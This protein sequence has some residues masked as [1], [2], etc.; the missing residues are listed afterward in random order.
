MTEIS[1]TIE[2]FPALKCRVGKWVYYL[3]SMPFSE[4]A[5]RVKQLPR[6]VDNRRLHVLLQREL[7]PER[8][9]Q[10]ARYLETFEERFFNAVVIGVEGVIRTGS[11]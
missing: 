1:G 2:Y 9:R 5:S 7:R 11:R 6:R 10:I 8:L 4:V 3:T